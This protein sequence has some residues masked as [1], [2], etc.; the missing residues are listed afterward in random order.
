MLFDGT[1]KQCL[2]S[3]QLG[4][5]FQWVSAYLLLLSSGHI[6]QNDQGAIFVSPSWMGQ[7]IIFHFSKRLLSSDSCSISVYN[8]TLVPCYIQYFQFSQ[9]STLEKTQNVLHLRYVLKKILKISHKIL[10]VLHS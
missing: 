4:G 3:V 6:H 8:V 9:N 5:H 7:R 2:Q 10:L 1:V